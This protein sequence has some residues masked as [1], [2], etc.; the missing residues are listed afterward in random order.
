MYFAVQQI[1]P[2]RAIAALLFPSGSHLQYGSAI[3]TVT[4]TH[5][6]QTYDAYPKPLGSVAMAEPLIQV[7]QQKKP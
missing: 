4:H 1:G 6:G 5:P 3:P 2:V 7:A